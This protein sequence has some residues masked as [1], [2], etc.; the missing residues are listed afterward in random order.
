MSYWLLK[1][2]P[3]TYE[4]DDLAK[5]RRTAWDG[6]KNPVALKHI[7]SM[8]KGDEAFLYHTGKERT[9]VGTCR[10]TRDPYPDPKQ[11]DPR[12]VVVDIEVGAPLPRPVT[13]AEMKTVAAL[14]GWDLF[15]LGRL[16]VV[17]VTAAQ[18]KTVRS[19]AR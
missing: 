13:L 5:D 14:A 1:T 19:I 11:D 17:P 16:S 3:G 8:K 12:L 10:V 4:W 6:V 18:W 15:R 7:R 2:D 9:I